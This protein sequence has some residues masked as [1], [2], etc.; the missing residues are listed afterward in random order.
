MNNSWV[1][2]MT[3]PCFYISESMGSQ[4][5]PSRPNNIMYE[6]KVM[7]IFHISPIWDGILEPTKTL[8]SSDNIS[9]NIANQYL[10]FVHE[11]QQYFG[12]TWLQFQLLKLHSFNHFLGALDMQP[13]HKIEETI[14]QRLKNYSLRGGNLIYIT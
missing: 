6:K 8:T 14:D 7:T 2:Q 9:K 13:T 12:S 10:K 4:Y 5:N 11:V 1:I 3:K